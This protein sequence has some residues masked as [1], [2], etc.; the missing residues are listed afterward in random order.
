VEFLVRTSGENDSLEEILLTNS[1]D[2][3]FL[4]FLVRISSENCL[5]LGFRV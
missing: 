2:N 4:E 3:F 1:S 5:G